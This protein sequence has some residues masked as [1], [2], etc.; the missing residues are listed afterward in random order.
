MEPLQPLSDED[1]EVFL[2]EKCLFLCASP[3]SVAF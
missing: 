1:T 3:V 2:L